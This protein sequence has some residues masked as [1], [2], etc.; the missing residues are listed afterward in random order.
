[1]LQ[2][3]RPLRAATEKLR[4]NKETLTPAH[5]EFLRVCLKAKAYHMALPLLDQPIFDICLSATNCSQ[6]TSQSFLCY[7]YYGALIRIG[8]KQ[9]VQALQMLLVVLTCPAQCLSAVQADAFKKYVLVSLKVHGEPTS[10]PIYTSHIVSRFA[11]SP[12]YV[13]EIAEAFKQGDLAGLQRLLEEKAAAIEADQN[14][15][16]VKQVI[17]SLKRHKIQTLTKTY[18]TLSISEIAREANLEGMSG[19]EVEEL[20]FDMVGNGEINALIDQT[21]G[22]VFFEDDQAEED[23]GP[24]MTAQLEERMGSILQLVARIADFER[25]VVSSDAYIQKTTA[26]EGDR[27]SAVAMAGLGGHDF[28]DM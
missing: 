28:M 7:Y 5:A 20:L 15:G 18:L 13:L 17:A 8:M 24:E 19:G 16:L 2:S 12:G 3:L 1:M 11:K 10:L 22:N 4:P 9:Y 21:S 14:L 6:L 23:V 25:Q 26:L 27:S